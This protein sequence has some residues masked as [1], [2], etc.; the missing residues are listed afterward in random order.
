MRGKSPPRCSR[1]CMTRSAVFRLS[2]LWG[3]TP[4][5]APCRHRWDQSSEQESPSSFPGPAQSVSLPPAL[6]LSLRLPPT[7]AP[8]P[9]TAFTIAAEAAPLTVHS[10]LPLRL[11]DIEPTH[12]G[13]T[14]SACL[15]G[16]EAAG[17]AGR[18]RLQN[19]RHRLP[20]CRTL[21]SRWGSRLPAGIRLIPDFEVIML[22]ASLKTG[23]YSLRFDQ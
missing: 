2:S 16:D 21:A 5:N 13:K 15:T 20:A 4:H 7:F 18:T 17:Q 12:R 19:Q 23:P 11:P 8:A 22:P 6:S 10:T 9:V 14:G 1:Q 3:G